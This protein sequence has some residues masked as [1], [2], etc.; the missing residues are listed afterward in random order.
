MIG[1]VQG[2]LVQK[3]PPLLLVDVGGVGYEIEAPMTTIYKLPEIGQDIYLY[4]HLVVREDAHL[5]FGFA[6]VEERRLFRNLI[7]VS[8]VGARMAL[9]ILSGIEADEFARCIQEGDTARLVRLP[10]IGRKTAERLV[11]EMRDRLSDWETPA[12]GGLAAAAAGG[13]D[14]VGEAVSALIALGYKPLEASRHVH[15]VA[16]DDMDCE[17]IIREALRVS[18]R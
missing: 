15:A 9:T 13:G 6:T 16:R 14:P 1:H 4:T 17:D 8:G 18:V 5:L 7:R 3:L 11:V 10:G 12:A 2:R